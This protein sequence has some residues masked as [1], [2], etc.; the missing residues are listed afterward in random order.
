L[1]VAAPKLLVVEVNAHGGPER[2]Q[3]VPYAANASWDGKSSF[4]G[5]TVNAFVRLCARHAYT[6]VYCESHGVNCFFARDDQLV[7][8]LRSPL[9]VRL[10]ARDGVDVAALEASYAAARASAAGTALA[11]SAWWEQD[12]L[13]TL[14]RAL[15]LDRLHRAPNF[16]GEGWTYP[17]SATRGGDWVEV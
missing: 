16:F 5:A 6:L 9:A 15:P 7:A 1:N 13:A 3:S 4:H 11:P 2:S 14:R 17:P 8:L 12:G 10:A